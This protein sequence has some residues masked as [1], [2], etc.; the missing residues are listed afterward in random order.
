MTYE[1][2]GECNES[3]LYADDAVIWKRGRNVSY[4]NDKVQKDIHRLIYLNSEELIGVLNFLFQSHRLC[5]LLGRKYNLQN[6]A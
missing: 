2:L 5:I 3:L 1:K 4:V 6:Y